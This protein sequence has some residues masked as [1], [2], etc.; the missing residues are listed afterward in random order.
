M[1]WTIER[2]WLAVAV[3]GFAAIYALPLT[4]LAWLDWRPVAFAVYEGAALLQWYAREHVILCLLPA[5]LYTG[6]AI[7]VIAIVMTAK[8]L[9]VQ[10]GIAQAVAA[11]LFA[12][13]IGLALVALRRGD[14]A[15]DWMA[16]AWGFAKQIMPLLIAGP[17]LVA[18]GTILVAGKAS[19]AEEIAALLPRG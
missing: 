2:R 19:A 7:D 15:Q 11:I 8:V 17:G 10:L 13:V 5:F 1:D 3:F 18:N 4:A 16:E 9:S 14:D 12:V 6:P